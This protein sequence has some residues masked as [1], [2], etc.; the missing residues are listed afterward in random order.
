MH[1]LFKQ[2][3]NERDLSRAGDLFSLS[4]TEIIHDLTEVIKKIT[5]ISSH[6]DYSQNDNDQSVVEICVTRVTSCIRETGTVEAHCRPLVALLEACL[7]HNLRPSTN[8]Q[9]EDPPHAKIASDVISCIFLAS[10]NQN[11]S[12]KG[13]MEAVLP[14]A[15]RLLHAGH[16]ELARNMARYLS[17][18]AIHHARLLKPHVQQIVDSIVAGNLAEMQKSG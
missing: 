16:A 1:D 4:D 15:V 9:N 17:L 13:V 5:E 18:A 14:V 6:P 8:H 12:K 10:D 11:Y 2:V 7:H 3:L